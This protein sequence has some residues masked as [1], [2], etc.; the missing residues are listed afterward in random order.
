[1]VGGLAGLVV[2][3]VVLDGGETPD[4][5]YRTPRRSAPHS[6]TPDLVHHTPRPPNSDAA[7]SD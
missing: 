5:V 7:L 3:G 4:E 1:M 2:G 6:P